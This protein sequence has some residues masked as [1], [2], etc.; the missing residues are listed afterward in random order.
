MDIGKHI[1]QYIEKV[2]SVPVTDCK[3]VSGGSINRAYVLHTAND[4]YFIK[5]NDSRYSGMFEAEAA[6]LELIAKTATIAV[7]QVI[8]S[9]TTEKEC[10]LL[11][12]WIDTQRPTPKTSAVLGTRLAKLHQCTSGYFGLDADNYMGSLIQSNKKHNTWAEFFINERLKPMVKVAVNKR[13]LNT[14][15]AA[16]FK[17]LYQNLP[18]LFKEEPSSLLHGDL[19]GGNYLISANGKPYLIDPAVYYGHREFDIALTTLFG[20]F[21]N[22]FYHAYNESFPLANG[23]E[24][25]I[26]LWNLYPVL[27]HVNLFGAGYVGQLRR[28]LK[29]YI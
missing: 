2:L 11:L 16:D 12:R 26:D 28:S 24:Q 8:L 7:P 14:D 13:L 15:D 25:R 22:E 19:W 10:F 21:T 5:I 23:W 4:K 6:S 29:Q 20:G 3:P 1:Q 27:V 9:G 18:G 17:I